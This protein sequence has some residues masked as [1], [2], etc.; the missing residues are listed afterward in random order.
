[1]TTIAEAH[2]ANIKALGYEVDEEKMLSE[3]LIL[4]SLTAKRRDCVANPFGANM[5]VLAFLN[6]KDLVRNLCVRIDL[7]RMLH[8]EAIIEVLETNK[9]ELVLEAVCSAIAQAER[10]M[11]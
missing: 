2:D 4:K 9:Q 11:K 6:K 10:I 3:F 7:V 8:V 1:M 5:N